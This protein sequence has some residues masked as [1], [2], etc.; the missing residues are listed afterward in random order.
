[1]SGTEI[2]CGAIVC[3]AMCGTEIAYG[4]GQRHSEEHEAQGRGMRCNVFG[5]AVQY[6]GVYCY[7]YLHIGTSTEP[8][9]VAT[10]SSGTNPAYV[11]TSF[12][13]STTPRL[14]P[15]VATLYGPTR[16]LCDVRH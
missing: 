14:P 8:A 5:F 16:W 4:A 9:Y 15:P 13:I 7:A 10:N 3:Y 11:A 6:T 1:M 12:R 2:A